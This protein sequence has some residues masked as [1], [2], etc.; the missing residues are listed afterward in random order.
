MKRTVLIL[1]QSEQPSGR[2]VNWFDG[3]M[4]VAVHESDRIEQ[5]KGWVD[6]STYFPVYD[7]S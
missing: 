1:I 2:Q 6:R 7:C 4:E 3:L 5:S